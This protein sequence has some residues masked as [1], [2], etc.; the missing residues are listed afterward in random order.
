MKSA[1]VLA[2]AEAVAPTQRR[3]RLLPPGPAEVCDQVRCF[4]YRAIVWKWQP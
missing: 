1:T 2:P 3:R 4:V